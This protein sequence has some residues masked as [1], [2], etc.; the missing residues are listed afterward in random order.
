MKVFYSN[1]NISINN[2]GNGSTAVELTLDCCRKKYKI[3]TFYT[4]N[5]DSSLNY[6]GNISK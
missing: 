1:E 4:F 5:G 3:M 2:F 6:T